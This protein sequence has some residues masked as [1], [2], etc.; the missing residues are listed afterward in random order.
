MEQDRISN[1]FAR[2]LT[3]EILPAELEE[4]NEL[5]QNNPD[6]EYYTQV[7][8]Q[9]WNAPPQENE[10][11]IIEAWQKHLERL[12]NKEEEGLT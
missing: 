11:G 10:S 1:L 3:E 2:W 6:L 8:S 7:I 4:F 9:W 5:L 12:R